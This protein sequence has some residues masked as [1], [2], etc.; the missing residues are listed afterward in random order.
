MTLVVVFESL[1]QQSYVDMHNSYYTHVKQRFKNDFFEPSC[2]VMANCLHCNV[3]GCIMQYS[4]TL[5]GFLKL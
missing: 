3:C 4:K 1:E 2:L 5:N